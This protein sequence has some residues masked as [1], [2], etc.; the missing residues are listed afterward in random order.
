[1][2]FETTVACPACGRQIIV[3][4]GR[5]T[6]HTNPA[7]RAGRGPI[8]RCEMAEKPALKMVQRP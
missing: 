8:P 2:G 3:E 5:F 4:Q 7:K 1:M 6:V